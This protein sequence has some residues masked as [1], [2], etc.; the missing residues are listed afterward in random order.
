[1]KF[2]KAHLQLRS[3][4]I[5]LVVL[6]ASGVLPAQSTGGRIVGR[7]ADPTGAVLSGVKVILTNTATG[8]TSE[9]TT[10]TSGDYNFVEVVPGEY[11][12][13]YEQAGFKK[14][15]QKAVTVELNAVVTLNSTLQVG[16]TQET[17]EVTSEAPLVDTTSTQLGATM[18][19]RQVSTLP[20]NSR[21]TYQLLQLQ[22]GVQ[23]VGGSDLFYGSN[24]AGAVSV[25]GGR[26]RS[27][28]FNVNGGDGNDLFVNSPAIQPT[29]DSIAEFRVL[30]NTFDAEYGRNSGAV[31]N[32]VTKSGTNKWHGSVYEFLRNQSFNAKGYLD[33]RKP[34]DKQNQF[35]GTFG[36]PIKKDRTF[37]F[38]S[39]E[40]RRVVHGITSDPV[41]VP[42]AAQRTGDF[43]GTPFDPSA[44]IGTQTFADILNARCNVGASLGSSY[45][46]LFPNNVIPANCFD[47]AAAAILQRFVPC[48]NADPT[49]TNLS[50]TDNTFRA[51]PN[52][53]SRANQF[54]LKL[55]HRINDRQNLSLYYYLNDGR[56]AQPFTRFQ[57]ATPNLLPGFGN[58]NATRSQQ[59]NL[60]HAWTINPTTVNEARF[61]YF[62]E[63]QGT[64]LHPQRT[65]L[66]TDS[67]GGAA[68]AFCFTGTSDTPG[69]IPT[70][71]RIGITPNL[72]A[73]REGVPFIGISGGFTIGNNFEGELP[74]KG[75]TYQFSNSLTKII[76]KHT[77]KFGV[78]F[79]NQR[80]LQT[81]YFDV[82]GDFSYFG[83]GLN[84]PIALDANG[85]QNLFPNYLLGLPDSYLQGSAQTE[86]IRG[87]SIYLFAQDSWKL[88][89][90]LTLNYGLRWE[91][92]E[93]I[94]DAGKRY[95]TFRP[96]Q[97][98]T[99]YPCQLS[100]ASQAS[101][102]YPDT[103][104][105]PGGSAAAVFP[106]GL[107]VPGDKGVPKGLTSSYYKAFAP[108]I[109]LAWDPL[110]NGKTTIRGGFGLFYN[111]IEQLV[112]EQ[113]QGEPPFGGSS[114]ISGGL[115]NT[116]FVSQS[117][118]T[119]N[120]TI[121]PNPFNGIL[122]PPH[123]QPIDWS[124]FRPILLFGELEPHLRSQYTA[125]YNFGIQRE[126]G[127][128]M[129]LSVGYV[130]SQG[131]R[132]LAT[133][134][135]NY[136]NAQTCIDLQNMSDSFGDPNLACGPFFADSAYTIP[137]TE[138][139]NGS[140]VPTVAPAG[141]LHIPYGPNGPTV[142]PAGTPI[143]SVAPNGINLVGLRRYS[144]PSCDPYTGTGC[145][146]DGVPVFSSIF[147]QDTIANSNYNSLQA[148]LEKRFTHGL[149][150]ELAY[151]F[152][153]SIDNASSFE[154]ILKPLCDRCNRA[155]SLFDARHRLVVSYLWQLP[156]PQY[157]GAK[158]K[159][160]N[161]WGVSGITSFQS[162]FP[163]RIQSSN[164]SELENSF[165][166]ELPGKPD[167]VAPF[168]T[169][170]PRK[171]GG[172]YFDPNSFT[173]PTQSASSTPLQ[174]LGNAPRTICCG[175]GISNF[176][177]SVQK[178]IPVGESKHFE[179]RAEF[180]NIFNHTQFL[181]PDGNISDGTDFGR[182]KRV[183]D[184]RNVQ[185]ALKF[186]F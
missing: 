76:G 166:F 129:V 18:N 71:P 113:F 26:G 92:N 107:V 41:V 100:A 60:S 124:S 125:Q 158:G 159:V 108:R 23:G 58:N 123:G 19:E 67:C 25:N 119:G 37:F 127:K 163:I 30:S 69:V 141:G 137:T 90:N 138:T 146:L 83:G 132:L 24:Q 29:P 140:I 74:Q 59:I 33:I 13:Q 178:L 56:D 101:L 66:V 142:I 81:L 173:L 110:N 65:N 105:N 46:S 156:I 61:T 131:H 82:N 114:L 80:F 87:N 97:A 165:D 62:R 47:P 93:P 103:N 16:G 152:S 157:E 63:A 17:V 84:D 35:G 43:S 1:M 98:T 14:N 53:R 154:N 27:N 172:Y 45:N 77:T 5:L 182:I 42:T 126:I 102:G 4:A 161:G 95:Q 121:S 145:P 78:D 174:L 86:D 133:K 149:Q 40:G 111:P 155:L 21:D 136:G 57:A 20:L 49:C 34:D 70:D 75:N 122:D 130:G 12:V 180:F 116:P 144:S 68:A 118:G 115:F 31:I 79:R 85:N 109:G 7:V 11:Q 143:A 2:L 54:T 147:A 170:D 184:P 167:L 177:F 139:V 148:S 151:T 94:Y 150:F 153:K 51:V 52:D 64:F 106:L 73:S 112:L 134:D 186:A 28:N 120:L 32:V 169:F 6:A 181:N 175:P 168:H 91:F 99:T 128:D 38:A 8:V 3:L 164:D 89:P 162:G 104:C 48:P 96:G 22:P 9:T 176:D 72:G 171:N 135:L 39:Y 117:G 15:L 55:D 179:F 183:R 44:L 185:F 36:G 50:N 10:N 88:K 160:L